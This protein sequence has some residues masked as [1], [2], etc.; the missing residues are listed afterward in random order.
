MSRYIEL[1]GS[2][3]F[4]SPQKEMDDWKIWV[5]SSRLNIWITYNNSIHYVMIHS[6]EFINLLDLLFI[7]R[8]ID[9][10]AKL[11]RSAW[12]HNA[13]STKSFIL[14]PSEKHRHYIHHDLVYFKNPNMAQ[15]FNS[16]PKLHIISLFRCFF[17]SLLH[18]F[19]FIQNCPW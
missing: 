15:N 17:L 12:H 18:P 16:I 1:Y 9:V 4:W 14:S 13:V 2:R 6:L 7:P 5:P 19:P 3:L 11:L 10:A 8:I